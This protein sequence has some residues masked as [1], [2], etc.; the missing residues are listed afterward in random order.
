MAHGPRRI[1]PDETLPPLML[2]T[3]DLSATNLL[4]LFGAQSFSLF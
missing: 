3:S 4:C 2:V 1:L